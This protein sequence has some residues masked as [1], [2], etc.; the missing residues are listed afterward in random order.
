MKNITIT[1]ARQNNLKNIDLEI[2]RDSIT[3]VT[4]VSGSGKSS[5]AFDTIYAEGQ[6]RYIESLSTYARQ[7]LEKLEKPD[8]DSISG[9]S[10]TIAIKR[11]NTV[12]SGRSTVGTATEI[13]DC[14]RLLYARIGKT[15]C[16]ECDEPVSSYS[17]GEAADR[18]IEG[19]SGKKV[20]ILL[21]FGDPGEEGWESKRKYLLSRGYLR[22]LISGQPVRIEE[23]DGPPPEELIVLIDR[24]EASE[25]KRKRI[26][27][28][29]EL[30]YRE[31][32]EAVEVR[33]VEE[34][35]SY[36]FTDRPTC[37]SCGREFSEP[38]PL[39]FSFNSP[40]GA[41]PDCKGYGDR[42][43]FSEN[44]I[45]PEPD[46]SIRDKAIDPWA[47]ERFDYFYHQ[48]L[49]FC[50]RKGIPDD[51]PYSRL[52]KDDRD[53]ILEGEGGFVGVIPFLE[54]MR[55]KAYKKG[56]RFFTRRYM[57]FA[58]CRTCGG[59]RLR[60]EAEYVRI[61][62]YS[63]SELNSRTPGEVLD[64]IESLEMDRREKKI[65]R[66]LINELVS[67]LRFMM[68]VGLE[69]LTL[70]RVSRTLS[71]G[72]SQRINLANSMGANLVDTVYI[73]DEP[74]VGLHAS[75]NDRLINVMKNLR[76]TGNTVIVVEH[77]PNIILASDYIIDLGPGAGSD[78]G[79]VVFSGYT[80]DAS[81]RRAGESR[82]LDYL[83]GRKKTAELK[84]RGREKKGSIHISGAGTHN[85]KNIN[86]EVPLGGLVVVT[87]VSGSG[88]SSL[89]VDTLYSL[90]SGGADSRPDIAGYNI[91][92]TV[93]SC[94]L[95]DQKP[96]GNTPRSNPVTFIKGFSFIRKIFSEQKRSLERGYK[97][98]RFSFN[99]PEGR[100]S[101]CRGMGY[102]RI[103]M[104]F[105]ADVF[106]PCEQCGGKR[107]NA[108]TLDVRYRGKDISEVLDL[109][110]N[111]ALLFFD[112]SP[113]LGEKLWLLS[114]VGL[115]YLKLGQPSNTLSG[116]EAQRIK[117]ARELSE[118]GEEKNL[119]IMDEPT[120][121]LHMSDIDNLLRIFRKLVKSGHTLLV[122]EHNLDVVARADW[123]IDLGP[124]GGEKGG[125]VVAF[126]H[127]EE[128]INKTDSLTGRYL[129]EYIEG[130]SR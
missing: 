103:E 48:L 43:E 111:E 45:V 40:Y 92:G 76:D 2:P 105:M 108:E 101:R 47:R 121:G 50:R 35:K 57:S 114:E 8:L 77:D 72:E 4:G 74:S 30:A 128:I 56:H 5:L 75:D 1:G 93:D 124:G 73:L 81:G 82:T 90:L 130:G 51:T 59:K 31:H 87:G 70:D 106:V 23:Y 20:Y 84:M 96:I 78:G 16:P 79:S 9:I 67:R 115:G 86:V 29:V 122:I 88:K 22:L 68:D 11:K 127:P 7:F 117:I 26:V 129:K 99:K 91:D 69:Y 58:T 100:C 42:M 53:R 102:R 125:E 97:P 38:T 112:G 24:V 12:K 36:T 95:V 14:L 116:G 113:R 18:V 46:R 104:H 17:P 61:G 21:P 41:C 62:G 39:F 60:A 63:I 37:H 118:S 13:Y 123:V 10:P 27:E 25:K 80:E 85:L 71:G 44:K 109:T 119:Y 98:G 89:V 15:Y 49:D 83:F 19:S 28:A 3:A 64:I 33:E 52:D 107:Y 6:R 55:K 65:S 120:T 66:D 94:S 126:G 54:K 34:K 32:T 110:V